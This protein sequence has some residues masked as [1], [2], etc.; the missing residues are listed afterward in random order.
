M[1]GI[2]RADEAAP[3]LTAPAP[4]PLPPALVAAAIVT[5]PV[6]PPAPLLRAFC[7]LGASLDCCELRQ[8]STISSSKR[9]R[10]MER[11]EL[12]TL[13]EITQVSINILYQITFTII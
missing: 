5:A 12:Q 6:A 4:P 10:F 1:A 8:Y 3:L 11:D 9:L 2:T 7:P 13:Y